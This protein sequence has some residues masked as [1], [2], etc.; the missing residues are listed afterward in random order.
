MASLP[1]FIGSEVLAM[2]PNTR[3]VIT[4][5]EAAQHQLRTAITLWFN[6]GDEISIHA[7]AFSAY[8]VMHT[9]SKRRNPYRRDLL[10]DTVLIKDE[11]RSDF[12]IQLKKSAS[13]F[14]HANR[15]TETEIEFVPEISEMF[16]FY[17]LA[18]RELCG[19]P[20]SME[21]SAYLWWI[22]LNKPSMLTDK[23]RKFTTDHVPPDVLD[24]LRTTPK[25][26]SSMRFRRRV[27]SELPW[28]SPL[29]SSNN[30]HIP[31]KKET[32]PVS[33]CQES[34]PHLPE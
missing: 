8:E 4:K 16:I 18:G 34:E 24:H 7:L 2:A 29:W 15:E 14:K 25:A 33:R 28:G 32:N 27:G 26:N 31:S 21:E 13:F 10:F 20:Q 22:Q 11:Y 30:R 9:L 6:E 3:M 12:N 19:H 23:G 5:I 1:I 17:A